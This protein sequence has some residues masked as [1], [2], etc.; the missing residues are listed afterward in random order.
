MTGWV[1]GLARDSGKSLTVKT[2][3]LENVFA[4]KKKTIQ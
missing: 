1:R 3:G 2:S 4:V